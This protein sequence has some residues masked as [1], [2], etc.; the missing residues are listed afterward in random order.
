VVYLGDIARDPKRTHEITLWYD[1]VE[2][3]YL[4]W[5]DTSKPDPFI[6]HFEERLMPVLLVEKPTPKDKPRAILLSWI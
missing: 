4:M 1:G 2:D 6:V 3:C 5:A